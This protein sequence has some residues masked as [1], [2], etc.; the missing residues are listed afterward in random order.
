[1][2]DE[3]LMQLIAIDRDQANRNSTWRDLLNQNADALEAAIKQR[4][5]DKRS[6]SRYRWMRGMRNRKRAADLMKYKINLDAAIDAAMA[7]ESG[8]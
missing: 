6:A 1:M 8:R 7:K 5:Q 4:E 3:A 2:A